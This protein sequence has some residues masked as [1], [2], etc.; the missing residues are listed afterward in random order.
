MVKKE[1]ANCFGINKINSIEIK[2]EAITKN[3][4]KMDYT[5]KIYK[6][7]FNPDYSEYE[8]TEIGTDEL[9]DFS[10]NDNINRDTTVEINEKIKLIVNFQYLKK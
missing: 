10:M 2:S 6:N 5:V 8:R 3:E 1:C 9:L 7:K 4:K